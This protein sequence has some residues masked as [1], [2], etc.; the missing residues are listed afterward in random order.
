MTNIT[1][2]ACNCKSFEKNELIHAHNQSNAVDNSI[3]HFSYEL[4]W[5]LGVLPQ[6]VLRS[7]PRNAQLITAANAR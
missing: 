4:I 1:V 3:S 7:S 5:R 2:V 6:S